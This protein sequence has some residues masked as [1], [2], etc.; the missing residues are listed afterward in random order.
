MCNTS[1][2]QQ[3]DVSPNPPMTPSLRSSTALLLTA[4]ALPASAAGLGE[5]TLHS[6]I[7]EPL[8][9]EVEILNGNTQALR[10]A[11]FS[12]QPIRNS[13]LPVL[14]SANLQLETRGERLILAI[15][16]G[17]RLREPLLSLRLQTGCGIQLQRDYLLMPEPPRTEAPTA[18]ESLRPARPA[19]PP[20]VTENRLPRAESRKTRAAVEK[21]TPTKPTRA[22]ARSDRLILDTSPLFDFALPPTVR[23]ETEARLLRM[24]TDLDHLNRTLAALEQR[25]AE[26]TTTAPDRLRLAPSLAL[27]TEPSAIR[28]RD[29][30][31]W[32]ELAFGTLLGGIGVAAALGWLEKRRRQTGLSRSTN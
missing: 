6:R 31:R 8:H 1:G 20:A 21:S 15:N 2:S 30:Q 25:A 13:E 16:S 5:L 9:A 22:A 3:T 23:E 18:S 27:P 17:Q 24:E 19:R 10:S 4:L 11:C 7:G 14:T 26:N 12:L 28:Q 32:L 29:H